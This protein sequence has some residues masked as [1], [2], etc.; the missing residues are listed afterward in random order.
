VSAILVSAVARAQDE[1]PIVI[2]EGQDLETVAVEEVDVALD[3]EGRWRQD[4][5]TPQ[6]GMKIRDRETFFR[7]TVELAT[8]GYLGHPNLVHLDL[9]GQF[10]LEQN[11]LS[12]GET[13]ITQRTSDTLLD[14]A[15]VADFLRNAKLPFTLYATRTST[16][17]D[18]QF[19]ST[20]DNSLSEYGGIVN[21]R[22][23]VAPMRLQVF[24]RD[25]RQS[26][27]LAGED[28]RLSQDSVTWHGDL[29]LQS[30]HHLAWD[31]SYDHVDETGFLRPTNTYERHDVFVTD[32][33]SF[34]ED[35]D[36]RSALRYLKQTG[37]FATESLRLDETLRVRHSRTLDTRY[38]Y[39]FDR[40]VFGD[41]TQSIHR[42]AARLRHQL[43]RSLITTAELGGSILNTEAQNFTSTQV[44]GNVDLEY[45]KDVPYG[46]LRATLDL[47]YTIQ[48]DG[49]RGTEFQIRDERRSFGSSGL[50]IIERRDI[51]PSSIVITDAT[52]VF[53]Y[54]EGFDYSVRATSERVEIRRLLGGN[55]SDGE[56]VLVSYRVGPEPAS[57]T[58]T[59]NYGGT[60][61]YTIDEGPLTGLALYG[62]YLEQIQ[63]RDGVDPTLP[64]SDFRD[65]LLGVDY[66]LRELSLN[67]EYEMRTGSFSPF[68]AL[69][70]EADYTHDLGA[71][72]AL[73]LTG[74]YQDIT[75][76]DDDINATI[77]TLS[78]RW[79]QQW[80][81][82]LRSALTLI[83][84]DER[85]SGSF[86]S[87]GFEQLLTLSWTYRQTA[88]YASVRNT[89]VDSDVR[90]T[91]A[92]LVRLG[93]RREF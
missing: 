25:E 70:L 36:L 37:D 82:H 31:Y 90:R 83:W 40:Q 30:W 11:D 81:P 78:G 33:Y 29:N 63:N 34:T 35:A 68:D 72:S 65:I 1:G 69:R 53:T 21:L 2:G 55:I 13:G 54:A 50:I 59:V 48:S 38:D 39:T 75:R 88:I 3:L 58:S 4:E 44:F 87:Q 22:S 71:G 32:D 14:Y 6:D 17:V 92:Q 77:A 51:V 79:S 27:P 56:V 7:E 18:R 61:R 45:T 43:F 62:R 76:T 84:R 57:D 19:G 64:E 46:S 20:L 60:L 89:F 42:G 23:D 9:R 24:H 67:A 12:D 74:V 28:F 49:E 86:D 26:D 16:L 15:A 52:R 8:R 66:D 80:D 5:T 73:S 85:D 47:G 91:D 10:G 41:D 93:F